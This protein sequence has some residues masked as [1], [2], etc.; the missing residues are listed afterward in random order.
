MNTLTVDALL[1][2][3]VDA[4][5]DTLSLTLPNDVTFKLCK[6]AFND[7]ASVLERAQNQS[8]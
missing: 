3:L 7:Q 2:L 4:L 5:G 8:V 1:G 6:C